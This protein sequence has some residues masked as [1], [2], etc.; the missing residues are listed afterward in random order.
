MKSCKITHVSKLG[1]FAAIILNSMIWSIVGIMKYDAYNAQVLDLGLNS[2]LLYGVLHP[3]FSFPH[4]AVN[5]LIYLLIAPFYNIYPDPRVLIIFQSTWLSLGAYPLYLI[6]MDRLKS[7]FPAMA[8]SLSYLLYF[9]MAGVYWYDFHFMA[10]FPTF[11]LFGFLFYLQGKWKLFTLIMA[12][13]AITD[14]LVPLI[15]VF[16]AVFLYVHESRNGRGKSNAA[17]YAL[18]T[19]MMAVVLF[20]IINIYFGFSY[21]LH[22]MNHPFTEHFFQ[23]LSSNVPEK[24]SYFTLLFIPVLFLSLLAPEV[25]IMI[26]PYLLFAVSHNYQP[27][28]VPYYYQYPALT[29]PIIFISAAFGLKRL[30]G[31]IPKKF[32][33]VDARKITATMLLWCIVLFVILTPIGNMITG[34]HY[35]YNAREQVTFT[36]NDAALNSMVSLIPKGSSVLIQGNMPQLTSGYHW[37]LPGGLNMSNPPQYAISD[38]YSHFYNDSIPISSPIYSNFSY[39]F[40]ELLVSGQYSVVDNVNGIVLIERNV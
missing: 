4:I 2:A 11:F 1:I 18:S 24:A 14:F 27:Y 40:N 35:P 38:P 7:D 6:S 3:A 31:I 13:A 16:F 25:L 33:R 28:F 9:P 32:H 26:V 20:V 34:T 36:R 21:T 22:W 10:L 19:I 23:S 29:A 8:V 37:I 12:L 15:L 39:V 30:V 17:R 5:K